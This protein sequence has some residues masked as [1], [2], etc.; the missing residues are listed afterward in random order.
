MNSK[1]GGHIFA[2]LIDKARKFDE[3]TK[4]LSQMWSIP[5]SFV[6]GR[7]DRKHEVDSYV[8]AL[9]HDLQYMQVKN[10]LNNIFLFEF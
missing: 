8:E 5:Q 6:C 4:E 7:S 9:Y 3:G 1:K 10:N 2:S